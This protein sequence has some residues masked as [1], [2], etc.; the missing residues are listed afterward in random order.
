[1][2]VIMRRFYVICFMF[3]LLLGINLSV[4]QSI[5]LDINTFFGLDGASTGLFIAL[6]CLGSLITP[7]LAGELSDRV[8]KKKVLMVSCVVFIVG[9]AIVS[10]SGSII[11]CCIGIFL[12][13]SGSCTIEGIFSAKIT[14]ENPQ[15]SEKLMNFSQLFFCVGA[16]AGPML[17]L[18]MKSLGADWQTIMLIVAAIFMPASISL[19]WIPGDKKAS[20]EPSTQNKAYS[21]I[22]I[23]N[24]KFLLFFFSMLFYIG[25]EVSVAFSITGYFSEG[26]QTVISGEIVL[27]L[28]W[29]GMII[30]RLIAGILHKL[31]DKVMII[32]LITGVVFSS[33][34]QFKFQTV[35]SMVL[36]FLLGLS[37]SAVWPLLM[38][39]CTQAF[40]RYSGTAGGLM[41]MGGSV[42][43]MTFPALMGAVAGVAGARAAMVVSTG[44]TAVTLV[45]YLLSRTK[46]A[47][48]VT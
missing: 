45:L 42:G 32:C 13:G 10:Q 39:F 4:Y 28:F 26:G 15:S 34:L 11:T 31:S 22:L 9:I 2:S 37:F 48:C 16:V 8:G 29:A 41:V 27:S 14:D 17:A 44:A 19:F 20:S 25:A 46:R 43:G 1:M 5:I 6:Y 40:T 18:F 38:A 21:L 12:I 7:T 30:G 3:M 24:A 33:L 36:F 35:I 23:K 47:N